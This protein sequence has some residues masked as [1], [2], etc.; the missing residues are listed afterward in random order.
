MACRGEVGVGLVIQQV[1][2]SQPGAPW[3]TTGCWTWRPTLGAPGGEGPVITGSH[4]PWS[5]GV[6]APG[7]ALPPEQPCSRGHLRV[8]S[9]GGGTF[10]SLPTL[11]LRHS[12]EP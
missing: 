1:L 7:L 8:A 10:L 3:G 9:R 4:T 6:W 12:L 5:L 11:C 2:C